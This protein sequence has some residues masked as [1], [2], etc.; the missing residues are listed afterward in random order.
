MKK[1]HF[2]IILLIPS[3]VFGADIGVPGQPLNQGQMIGGVGADGNYHFLLLGNDGS[4]SLSGGS[5]SNGVAQGST[6]SG[7][8]GPL[9]QGAVTTSNPSYTTG[10]TSPLSLDT[11]GNLRVSGTFGGLSQGSTTL[12]QTGS[13]IQG[14]VTTAAP[15]YTTAQTNPLSLTTAGGL[16]TDNTTIAGTTIDT[17]SGSKSA[18]TQRVVIATDQPALTN[19]LLVTPDANSAVNVAQMN[20]VAV[21]MNSGTKS[22]GTQR[23]V[24]ATDQPALTNTLSVN[25]TNWPA[26]VDTNS[27]NKSANTPRFVL[28]TDQPNLTTALNVKPP[29]RT[30]WVTGQVTTSGTAGT[31]V[32][33]NSTRRRC[34][35]KNLDATITVYVGPATVTTSNGMEV[36]AGQSIEITATPLIQVIAASGTPVVAY[37]DESD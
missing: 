18:G 34:V 4:L 13:L 19:K 3:F 11:S 31:L 8:V 21:D 33:S 24:L 1:C 10:Q 26:T 30:T 2:L 15:A 29:V 32:A 25:G 9:S 14:A 5:I 17:N 35:I 37:S 12:G 16:R 36:K 28:A 23:V 6:T 22:N 7:Q 27:G 20:G